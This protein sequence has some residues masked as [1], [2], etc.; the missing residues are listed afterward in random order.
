MIEII[1][2]NYQILKL[3]LSAQRTTGK[4]IAGFTTGFSN[5]VFT[6]RNQRAAIVGADRVGDEVSCM[7]GAQ[8]IAGE[9][10]LATGI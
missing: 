6:T 5:A 10:G 2:R 1:I 9:I 3:I 4:V 7:P 8:S